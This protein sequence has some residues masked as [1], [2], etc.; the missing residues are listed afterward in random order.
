M[1]K[2]EH[3]ARYKCVLVPMKAVG[4]LMIPAVVVNLFVEGGPAAKEPAE[5]HIGANSDLLQLECKKVVHAQ[6]IGLQMHK[7]DRVSL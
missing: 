5:I 7:R 1:E 2:N 3:N 4:W 6:L